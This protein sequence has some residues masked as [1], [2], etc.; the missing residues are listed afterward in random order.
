MTTY[1]P[2][3]YTQLLAY[4]Y[5]IEPKDLEALKID[6]ASLNTSSLH[7]LLVKNSEDKWFFTNGNK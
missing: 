1:G 7:I 3:I 5:S 2:I 6:V 4:P